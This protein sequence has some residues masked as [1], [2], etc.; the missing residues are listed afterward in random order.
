MLKTLCP[1][2]FRRYSSL[3]ILGPM[4]DG[5]TTWLL[6]QRYTRRDGDRRTRR[7]GRDGT[8]RG[9]RDRG[10]RNVPKFAS[11]RWHILLCPNSRTKNGCNEP[12]SA[13]I[14][15]NSAARPSPALNRSVQSATRRCIKLVNTWNPISTDR[16][17]RN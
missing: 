16:L 4:V 2:S 6:Q 3:A 17:S 10:R 7:D 14:V 5:F 15:F 9:G 13:A 11:T 8:R 12:V 1:A